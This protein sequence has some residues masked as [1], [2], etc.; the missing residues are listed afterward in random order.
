[1]LQELLK[2]FGGGD[3]L[4]AIADNFSQMLELARDNRLPVHLLTKSPAE[5]ADGLQAYYRRSADGLSADLGAMDKGRQ[6]ALVGHGQ[7]QRAQGHEDELLQL[8]PPHGAAL[9][10]DLL[11][12]HDDEVVDAEDIAE[13]VAIWT[14]IPVNSLLQTEAEK[15]LVVQSFAGVED[16]VI[17]RSAHERVGLWSLVVGALGGVRSTVQLWVVASASSCQLPAWSRVRR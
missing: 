4:R 12:R 1:M 8:G 16:R 13:V 15:L 10:E 5:K 9:A 6:Q 2:I 3:P 17:G 11:L 7:Q 14:G